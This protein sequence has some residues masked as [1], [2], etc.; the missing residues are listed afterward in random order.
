MQ[1]IWISDHDT[2]LALDFNDPV[3][4]KMLKY[5]AHGSFGQTKIFGG[6]VTMYRDEKLRTISAESR[7]L[8]KQKNKIRDLHH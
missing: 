6:V 7:Y 4:D 3:G 1:G 8:T 5:T 2:L